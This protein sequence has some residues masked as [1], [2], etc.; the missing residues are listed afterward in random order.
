MGTIRSGTDEIRRVIF[1]RI[2]DGFDFTTVNGLTSAP[3]FTQN[4]QRDTPEP[5][6]YIYSVE[7]AEADVTKDAASKEYTIN[8]EVLIRYNSRRGGQRQADEM[9]DEVIRDVRG[10]ATGEYPDA[11][12]AGYNIYI[13][14]TGTQQSFTFKERGANYY[15]VILPVYVTASFEGTDANTFPVQPVIFNSASFEFNP[16]ATRQIE[17]F[18]SGIVTFASQ[19]PSGN[20]GWNFDNVNY[21]LATNAQGSLVNQTYTIDTDDTPLGIDSAIEYTLDTD[22]TTTHTLTET[23]AFPRIRSVRAG[24]ADTAQLTALE[25]DN[26]SLWDINYGLVDPTA[27]NLTVTT[28]IGE[29]I[30]FIYDSAQGDLTRIENLN[31][32]SGNDLPLYTLTKQDGFNIYTKDTGA[33]FAGD[34]TFKLFT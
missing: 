28:I 3:T 1:T 7:S 8:V 15:K 9:I 26:F 33:A 18:D 16:D 6:I 31:Q 29:R 4:P 19:Y 2:R 34:V 10:F 12:A 14:T 30:Y 13:I 25:L 24:L 32:P 11:T 17:W 20:N 27:Q 23:V 21:T 5:Y 22:I